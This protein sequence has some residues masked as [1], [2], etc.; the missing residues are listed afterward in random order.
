MST[1]VRKR[2]GG[3]PCCHRQW[4]ATSHC[5]YLHGYDRW[6]EIEWTGPRDDLGWVVDFGGLKELKDKLERPFDHT[7]LISPD[8]PELDRF[9]ELDAAGAID[10][11]VMDPTMEGMTLW[12][13]DL[14]HD[15]QPSIAEAAEVVRIECW[16]NERNAAVWTSQP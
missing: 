4:K 10:L 12:V 16:E 7:C 15:L 9:R 8:D 6:V 11:R 13:R 5:R 14:I 2:L 1:N 3:F